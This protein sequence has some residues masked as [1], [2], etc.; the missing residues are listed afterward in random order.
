M[1]HRYSCARLTGAS[2]EG[3]DDGCSHVV[4]IIEAADRQVMLWFSGCAVTLSFAK[5]FSTLCTLTESHRPLFMLLSSGYGQLPP[6][7]HRVVSKRE[8]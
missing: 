4:M 5:S 3:S 1:P 7:L 6:V 8:L 2:D